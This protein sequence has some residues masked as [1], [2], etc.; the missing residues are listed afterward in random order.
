MPLR[1]RLHL[2]TVRHGGEKELAKDIPKVKAKVTAFSRIT[3][4]MQRG[5][6]S[7]EDA[8]KAK[9]YVRDLLYD[10]LRDM[11]TSVEAFEQSISSERV[12]QNCGITRTANPRGR[13]PKAK[14]GDA[15]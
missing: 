11:D 14:A 9:D 2:P 15:P 6:I 13:P 1:P 5:A 3:K 10:A 7:Q 4:D 8:R 12:Y